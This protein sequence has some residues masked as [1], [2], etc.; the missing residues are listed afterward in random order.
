MQAP[1]QDL[2]ELEK[3]AFRR[4]YD[5]GLLDLLLGLMMVGMSLGY[6]VQEWLDSEVA[7]LSAMLGVAVVLVATLK[8]SRTRLLDS[9]LGRFTPADRRRRKIHRT[10]LALLGSAALGVIA[11]A[12]GAVGQSDGQSMA[13]VE[14]LLP[15]LWF[16]NATVVLG[17]T[18]YL[19]DVPRFA[20]YGILFGLVGPLQIWPDVLWDVRVPPPLAFGLPAMPIIAIGLWRLMRFLRDYPVQRRQDAVGRPAG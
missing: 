7:G 16:V 1:L 18:A 15:L 5:D 10:R 3:Q 19:L 4:F 12:L 8:V 17:I 20:L 11:F 2:E 6:Y 13:S 9:R 14:V